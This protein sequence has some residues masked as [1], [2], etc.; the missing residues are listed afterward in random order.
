MKEYKIEQNEYKVEKSLT[1]VECY[2]ITAGSEDE[3]LEKVMSGLYEKDSEYIIDEY[4]EIADSDV[5]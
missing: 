1:I 2:T 5:E 4:V 3:A